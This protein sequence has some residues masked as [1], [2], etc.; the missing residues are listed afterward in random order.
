M[1]FIDMH[2]DTLYALEKHRDYQLRSNNL[3]IDLLK[4]KESHYL[5]QNFAIFTDIASDKDPEFHVLRCIDIFYQEME[6]N[7]DLIAPITSYA[8]IIENNLHNVMSA[9]LT[10]EEGAVINHDLALLR[11]YYRLGVRMIALS[12]NHENG[13]THPNFKNKTG[14]HTFNN[15]GL[16]DFG[17]EYIK[18]MD[19]LGIIVDVSHMSDGCFYDVAN[20]IK[21]PF[22][23]SHSNARSLCDHARNLTDD[24]IKVIADHNGVIGINFADG[25]LAENASQSLIDDMIRHILY[26]RDLVGINYIGL[27]SDF[28]GISCPLEIKNASYMP[29]LYQRLKEYLSYED[30]QKIL[31]KNVLR[32]YQ[33]VLK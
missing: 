29:L 17:K 20:I 9:M 27:G 25:F 13:I 10:L 2:C 16:T 32:V 1:R 19:R 21:G 22:V 23:A 5:L 31:Y 6:K 3:H 15:E 11:N 24:M 8:Q 26:I 14:Y 12:W 28:D 7:K 18:E 33:E 30:I 4:M